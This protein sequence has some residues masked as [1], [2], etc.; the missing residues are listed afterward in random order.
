[1]SSS[2][3]AKHALRL[4][5]GITLGLAVVAC[6][7][8]YALSKNAGP[9]SASIEAPQKSSPIASSAAL[10]KD[11]EAPAPETNN[12]EPYKNTCPNYPI[13]EVAKR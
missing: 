11:H 4:W 3:S 1:M 13:K 2:L 7:S 5:G 10:P 12:D 9:G 6:L 8:L